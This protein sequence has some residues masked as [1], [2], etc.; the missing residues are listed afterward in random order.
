M[1]NTFTDAVVAAGG[2]TGNYISKADLQ[3]YGVDLG[4]YTDAAILEFIQTAES[5]IEKYTKTRFYS[6]SLTLYLDGK[7]NSYLYFA[8]VTHLKCLTVV[9]VDIWDRDDGVS[10]DSLTTPGDYILHSD[11]EYLLRAGGGSTKRMTESDPYYLIW[12]VGQENVKVVGTFGESA[13]PKPIKWACALLVAKR[14]HPDFSGLYENVSIKWPDFAV[15][16]ASTGRRI[17]TVT[18]IPSVDSVINAYKRT[19]LMLGSP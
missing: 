10:E 6:G 13:V 8:P 2:T 14:I 1:G 9:S 17:K 18:G 4:S 12:P 3:T 5:L 15:T 16:R 19:S 11:G 7:G